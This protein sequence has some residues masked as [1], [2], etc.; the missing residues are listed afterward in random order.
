MHWLDR[1]PPLSCAAEQL[2]PIAR[3]LQLADPLATLRIGKIRRFW[4]TRDKKRIES[5]LDRLYRYGLSLARNEDHARELVQATAVKALSARRV[6]RDEPA[7]RAWLFRVLRNDFL[8][9]MRRDRRAE[10]FL[11]DDPPDEAEMEYWGGDERFINV[12]SVRLALDRLPAL[13]R[14][15]LALVD[16][17]GFSYQEAAEMLDVP[18]GTIMSRVSRAR[19]RLLE[20]IEDSN[21]RALPSRRRESC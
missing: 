10:E 5:Y 11:L 21:I 3:P 2:E 17:A 13:H 9:R 8:D 16:V 1:T 19:R 4:V 6:P 18:V 7:Y 20:A 14:E 15:I 12:V